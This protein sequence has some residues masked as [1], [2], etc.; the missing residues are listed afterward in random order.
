MSNWIPASK[1]T[2]WNE[3]ISLKDKKLQ[4]LTQEET[5]NVKRSTSTEMEL[6]IRKTNHTKNS[7]E[8]FT[9]EFYQIFKE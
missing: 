2:R 7:P 8:G 9:G 4:K 3:Q 1:I 5:E 6:V